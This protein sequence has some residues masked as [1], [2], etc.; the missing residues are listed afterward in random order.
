MGL[1]LY[2]WSSTGASQLYMG[3]CYPTIN[4]G[5]D[6]WTGL[7]H[8]ATLT[9][10]PE[11]SNAGPGTVVTRPGGTLSEPTPPELADRWAIPIP[12]GFVVGAGLVLIA[13]AIRRTLGRKAG[14]SESVA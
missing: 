2:L 14:A 9:C 12:L 8:G 6:P 5:F 11:Q 3:F 4:S 13:P 10:S 7:P 1:G